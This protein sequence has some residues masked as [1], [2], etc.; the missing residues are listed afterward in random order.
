MR[1]LKDESVNLRAILTVILMYDPV[2]EGYLLKELFETARLYLIQGRSDGG[3][4]DAGSDAKGDR[5]V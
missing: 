3:S 5:P 1:D 4:G 2:T